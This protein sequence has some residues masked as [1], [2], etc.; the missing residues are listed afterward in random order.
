[1]PD[2]DDFKSTLDELEKAML[3]SQ[4]L[5]QQVKPP[6]TEAPPKKTQVNLPPPDKITEYTRRAEED[7]P[8]I[9]SLR[10]KME[11][12]ARNHRVP[13]E[14]LEGIASRESRGGKA[15]N[16]MGYDD[17][18]QAFGVMQVDQNYHK[19]EGVNAPDSQ[20]HIDQAARILRDDKRQMDKKFPKWSDEER[21]RAAIAAYNMGSGNVKTKEQVDK[22]TTGGDYSQDVLIRAQTFRQRFHTNKKKR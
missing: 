10:S 18:K 8:R 17:E 9:A 15:L 19:L 2:P 22:G 21:W 11:A 12:A 16:A 1:M 14:Y 3:Q 5:E 20:A 7:V 13:V 6:I 4:G